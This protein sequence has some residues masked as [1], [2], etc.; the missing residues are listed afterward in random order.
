MLKKSI[1]KYLKK[2]KDKLLYERIKKYRGRELSDDIIDY[3]EKHQVYFSLTTSPNRL[4]K[5][6]VVLSIILK[7]PFVK[8]IH[9]NLPRRY[10]NQEPYSQD[11]I[12]Y[13]KSFSDKVKVYR[14]Q[15]D[16]GPLT[17]IVPTLKRVK[18][19]K[20]LIISIDDDIAYPLS[21]YKE[22]L[23]YNYHYPDYI[24]TGSGFGLREAGTPLNIKRRDWNIHKGEKIKGCE[25]VE[26]VE[27][28][29]MIGYK[30]DFLDIKGVL[31][32][33]SLSTPCKLS[34]DL[35]ISY[36]LA[37]ARI[38]RYMIINKYYDVYKQLRSF[39]YGQESDALSM[40]SGLGKK[41]DVFANY[42]K[43]NKCIKDIVNK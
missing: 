30:K 15:K 39:S 6:A 26:I 20:R 42:R 11:D 8:Q 25:N 43:Y 37:K 13:I 29:G 3:Y 10:R 4:R 23:Y 28:W 33:N 27:G 1:V 34:D 5:F 14:V 40:G 31:K 22:M 24:F 36:L 12:D 7:F 17:K 41:V 18:S 21:L 19:K 9:I 35:T 2:T 32:L 38:N 16:I